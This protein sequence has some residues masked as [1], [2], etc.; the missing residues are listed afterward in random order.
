MGSYGIKLNAGRKEIYAAGIVLAGL[1]VLGFV[2]SSQPAPAAQSR[3]LGD[4][5]Y[6]NSVTISGV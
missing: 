5:D 6:K 3:F 1:A 2:L 4:T